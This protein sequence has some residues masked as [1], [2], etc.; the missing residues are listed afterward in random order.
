[1]QLQLDSATLQLA[2]GQL[3]RLE[4]AAGHVVRSHD[5]AVWITEDGQPRDIVLREGESYRLTGDALVLVHALRDSRVS[6]S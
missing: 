3:V 5:G 2:R 1:M 4:D 6:V